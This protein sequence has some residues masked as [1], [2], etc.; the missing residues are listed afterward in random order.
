MFA[1]EL[2]NR[3][4]YGAKLAAD[5]IIGMLEDE[6]T[7][8]K[9][10]DVNMS[11]AIMVDKQTA[12]SGRAAQGAQVNVQINNYG[13]MGRAEMMEHARKMAGIRGERIDV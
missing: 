5:R 10:S 13:T 9:L 2:G 4:R 3:L 11:L 8:Q 7:P 6:D 1:E 12:I